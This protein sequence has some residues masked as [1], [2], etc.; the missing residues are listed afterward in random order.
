MFTSN[1]TARERVSRR[2][3]ADGG[4]IL[5]LDDI[6]L[7]PKV[8]DIPGADLLPLQPGPAPHRQRH[9]RQP[10]RGQVRRLPRP[11]R[12][13]PTVGPSAAAPNASACTPCWCP[14]SA[15][16]ATWSRPCRCCSS[17]SSRF[18]G[19]ARHPLRVHEHGRRAGDPLPARRTSR[20]TSRP[21]APRS[22]E[23]CSSASK[24]RTGYAPGSTWKAAAIMTGPHGVAGGHGRSTARTSTAPT[25]GWTPACRR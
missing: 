22:T 19:A 12:R 4:C 3:A 25:S 18:P 9:H 11:D 14:T 24:T 1:N 17:W 6:S 7:V 13:M 2:R 15:T 5:N 16:T 20:S 8:P 21:S 10:G 23:L